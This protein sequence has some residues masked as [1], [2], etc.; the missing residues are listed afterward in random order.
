[1]IPVILCPESLLGSPWSERRRE[2]EKEKESVREIGDLR[3]E[4][5]S[6]TGNEQ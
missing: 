2:R 3:V 4:K 6:F 5:E 1:M